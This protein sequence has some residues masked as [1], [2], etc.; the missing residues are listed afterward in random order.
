MSEVEQFN[1][2]VCFKEL[3]KMQ[4]HYGAITC[5]SCRTFFRRF[6]LKDSLP[7]CCLQR[8]NS[9]TAEIKTRKSCKY[10]RYQKC[11][12][13]IFKMFSKHFIDIF[14]GLVCR[15]ILIPQGTFLHCIMKT[16]IVRRAE[17]NH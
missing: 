14:T 12:R 9:G 15:C 6:S 16:W 7:P 2:E 13:Y 10:C 8:T 17:P 11:L 3:C 5:H 4:V 1:C